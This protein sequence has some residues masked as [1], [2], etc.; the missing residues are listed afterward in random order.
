MNLKFWWPW[1]D[2]NE[3]K[4]TYTVE[5]IKELLEKVKEFDAGCIDQYLT[6]HVDRVFEKWL[7]EN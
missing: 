2:T 3:S 6:E 7:E 1:W 5:E 4:K